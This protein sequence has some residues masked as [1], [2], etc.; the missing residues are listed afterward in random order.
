VSQ[1]LKFAADTIPRKTNVLRF[2]SVIFLLKKANVC[3][4]YNKSLQ[5]VI[6]FKKYAIFAFHLTKGCR[7]AML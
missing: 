6:K 7:M 2:I 4:F 5:S 1:L 3:V